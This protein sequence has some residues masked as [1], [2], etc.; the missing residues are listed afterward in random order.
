MG[1]GS[2]G[3]HTSSGVLRTWLIGFVAA[4]GQHPVVGAVRG[5]DHQNLSPVNG[6][7][8]YTGDES[9]SICCISCPIQE[10]KKTKKK[11]GEGVS[12]G[13]PQK[14]RKGKERRI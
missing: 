9:R 14:E 2:E 12:K 10:G 7:G 13:V 5:L 1:D 3:M 11:K 8:D 6:N 4:L